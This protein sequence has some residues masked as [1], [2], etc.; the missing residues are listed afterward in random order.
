MHGFIVTSIERFV[1]TAHGAQTWS[2]LLANAG[3][4]HK[5]YENWQE[6]PD[7]EVVQLVVT[8]AA[9]DAF[10]KFAFLTNPATFFEGTPQQ[11]PVIATGDFQDIAPALTAAAGT[12]TTTACCYG[13]RPTS[14]TG[15]CSRARSTSIRLIDPH[16]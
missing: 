10:I 14:T 15:T 7:A 2:L 11:P 5:R 1:T 6:Y 4:P 16:W 8:G 9:G 3:Y 12:I 13:R